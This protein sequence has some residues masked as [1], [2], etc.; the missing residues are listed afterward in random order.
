MSN[1]VWINSDDAWRRA[2]SSV[3]QNRWPMAEH[4]FEMALDR[5]FA[6]APP[7]ADADL[8]AVLVED[9]MHR[10]WTFRR[11]VI[12]VLRL[13]GRPSGGGPPLG[14]TVYGHR[15]AVPAPY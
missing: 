8:F 6:E 5:M 4:D 9:R 11:L 1:V 14:C 10:G 2:A 15:D 12:G 7:F 3:S 13:A